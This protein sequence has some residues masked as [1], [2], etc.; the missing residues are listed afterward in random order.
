M[1]RNLTPTKV[2][3]SVALV[4]L[5]GAMVGAALLVETAPGYYCTGDCTSRADIVGAIFG[6]HETGTVIG[7]PGLL[8]LYQVIGAIAAVTLV[9]NKI[10]D[11][12][13]ED[14]RGA[15]VGSGR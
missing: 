4:A 12:R 7:N 8:T 3:G 10:V 5:L 14:A 11:K 1:L 2:V 6:L 9:V 13:I 15:D